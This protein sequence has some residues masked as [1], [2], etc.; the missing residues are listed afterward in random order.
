MAIQS[1]V[2]Q[3]RRNTS[4]VMARLDCHFKHEGNSYEAVIVDLS[5]KGAF[6]SAKILPPNGSVVTVDM[7][8]PAVKRPLSF[9]GVVIRGTWGMSEHGKLGRFGIRFSD[10]PLDLLTLIAKLHS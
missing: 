1:R 10:T 7:Q 3:D 5:I 6:L 2:S 9:K 4:R 8:P